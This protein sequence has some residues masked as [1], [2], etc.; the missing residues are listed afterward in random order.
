M[1]GS[2][3]WTGEKGQREKP[4]DEDCG[5]PIISALWLLLFAE[6]GTAITI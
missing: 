5:G 6:Q 4:R 3:A 1:F 2:Q